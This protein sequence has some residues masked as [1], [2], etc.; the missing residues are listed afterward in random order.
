VANLPRKIVRGSKPN[1]AHAKRPRDG[2]HRSR[3]IR[4]RPR[5]AIDRSRLLKKVAFGKS[6]SLDQYWSV[7]GFVLVMWKPLQ[8][9]LLAKC[10]QG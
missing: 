7:A 1:C 5:L 6:G 3:P 2:S 10:V 8:N 4:A 9:W